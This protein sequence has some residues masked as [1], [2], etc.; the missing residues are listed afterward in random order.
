MTMQSGSD[1]SKDWHESRDGDDCWDWDDSVDWDDW[2]DWEDYESEHDQPRVLVVGEKPAVAG[3]LRRALRNQP[4]LEFDQVEWVFTSTRGHV[5]DIQF[6]GPL[7]SWDYRYDCYHVPKQAQAFEQELESFSIDEQKRD[8]QQRSR[9]VFGQ[10]DVVEDILSEAC[11]S[12]DFLVLCLDNDLEG[13]CIAAEV[14]SILEPKLLPPNFGIQQQVWRCTFSSLDQDSLRRAVELPPYGT[15]GEINRNFVEAVRVRRQLDLRL[16]FAFSRAQKYLVWNYLQSRFCTDT[17]RERILHVCQGLEGD[18]EENDEDDAGLD[19]PDAELADHDV[20]IR[21]QVFDPYQWPVLSYGPCQIPTLGFVV[22][23][24]VDLKSTLPR[25]FWKVKTQCQAGG[26]EW[27]VWSQPFDEQRLA[28]DEARRLQDALAQSKPVHVKLEQSIAEGYKRPHALNTPRMLQLASDCLGLSPWR[29]LNL[30]EDLYLKAFISYPRSET[31]SYDPETDLERIAASIAADQPVSDEVAQFAHVLVNEGLAAP[32]QDGQDAGDHSP[33]IPLV[34]LAGK[35]LH[36]VAADLYDLICRVFLA[37]VSPDA[38]IV[39]TSLIV[40]VPFADCSLTATGFRVDSLGWIEV[41][42]IL[43]PE[44]SELPDGAFQAGVDGLP[45]TIQ[46]ISVERFETDRPSRL[47]EAQLLALMEE[48]GIGTDASMPGHIEKIIERSYVRVEVSGRQQHP[49][50]RV[51]DFVPDHWFRTLRVL[52]PTLQG[53][54]L[55]RWYML[56]GKDLAM[57]TV[58]AN[59]E[60]AYLQVSRGE[61]HGQDVLKEFIEMFWWQ[62]WEIFDWESNRSAN[63]SKSLINFLKQSPEQYQQCSAVREVRMSKTPTVSQEWQ[64]AERMIRGTRL[65]DL[66][67][68]RRQEMEKSIQSAPAAV[69]INHCLSMDAQVRGPSGDLAEV[70]TLR[71]GDSLSAVFV[72]DGQLERG[73]CSVSSFRCFQPRER[74]IAL[75]SLSNRHRSSVKITSN[76]HFMAK[77]LPVSSPW[78]PMVVRDLTCLHI[79]A[80]DPSVSSGEIGPPG[81]IQVSEVSVQRENTKVIELKLD[82]GEVACWLFANPTGCVATYGEVPYICSA[83]G[84]H[85]A[86]WGFSRCPRGFRDAL[87]TSVE[88]RDCREALID[89]GFSFQFKSGGHIFVQPQDMELVQRAL[90]I[91]GHAP[92]ASEVVVAPEFEVQLQEAL[93]LLSSRASVYPRRQEEVQ[94]DT[95]MGDVAAY[96]NGRPFSYVTG[97]RVVTGR[98]TFIDLEAEDLTPSVV[99]ASTSDLRNRGDGGNNPNPRAHAAARLRGYY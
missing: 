53:S 79:V 78:G 48:H 2:D 1:R 26:Q 22:K 61:R 24:D 63:A 28:N 86:M 60:A 41:L 68:S 27:A 50:E 21:R 94:L 55:F 80:F 13:E 14:E 46:D 66:V 19:D 4:F 15:L 11:K 77:R 16:G 49:A 92:R 72:Q 47:T 64:K 99:T 51:S 37:S 97:N 76:H 34:Q 69:P 59:V 71:V 96:M 33:I 18:E 20:D 57:P 65:E 52:H 54:A 84:R 93:G 58:R 7:P 73:E 39:K 35:T 62:F 3:S 17:E 91:R 8:Q 90:R 31:E 45:L 70:P 67:T 38:V 36:G 87:R 95:A 42:P 56:F 85:V 29:A 6:K 12:I 25:P 82:C 88:L 98:R 30:A 23:N 32:R 81:K 83:N 44:D 75:L 43:Q 5:Q 74:D 10:P 89:A 40:E 9:Q